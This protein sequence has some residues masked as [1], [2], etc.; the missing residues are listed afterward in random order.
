MSTDDW[1]QEKPDLERSLEDGAEK[2]EMLSSRLL[3]VVSHLVPVVPSVRKCP[4]VKSRTRP[5]MASFD[6][7]KG[8]L[9]SMQGPVKVEFVVILS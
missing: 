7:F 5:V 6:S 9:D 4:S 3:V 8:L 1:E 2:R